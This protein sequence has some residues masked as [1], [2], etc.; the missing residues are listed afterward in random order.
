MT[1]AEPIDFDAFAKALPEVVAG[2]RA[3]SAAAGE[4]MDKVLIELIKA[5]ASQ[6]NGCAFCL[7]L[8]LN[9]ARKAGA[10][11]A[12]LDRLAVWREAPDFTETERA[13]L[14]W[15][16]A[17]TDPSR[18]MEAPGARAALD[19]VFDAPAVMRLTAA[20]AAINAWNRIAGPLGFTPP[21]PGP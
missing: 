14:G 15:T 9:W 11:Q 17:L 7:Q 18:R 8:H 16:E 1:A 2:L 21:A 20:V 4:G 10:T 13:A 6:I 19:A 3:L 12:K 5:R